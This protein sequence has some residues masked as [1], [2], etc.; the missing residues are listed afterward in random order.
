[1]T[2][3]KEVG[4]LLQLYGTN[5]TFLRRKGRKKTNFLGTYLG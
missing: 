5:F 3:E 2:V 1:M 4:I